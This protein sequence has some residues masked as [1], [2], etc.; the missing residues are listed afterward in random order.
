M[1]SQGLKI[2]PVQKGRVYGPEEDHE[3]HV[4]IRHWVNER[5][6]AIALLPIIP[7]AL[8]YPN[9]LMDNVL[10]TSVMLHT[11]WSVLFAC[12]LLVLILSLFQAPERCGW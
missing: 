12:Y 9:A 1:P 8:V 2:S 7:S 11:H 3:R 4:E 5:L 10:V 6:I